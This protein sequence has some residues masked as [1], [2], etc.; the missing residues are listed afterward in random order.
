MPKQT[1]LDFYV[2]KMKFKPQASIQ[3]SGINI[4]NTVTLSTI[5]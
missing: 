2:N 5:T 1:M 4:F 3:K